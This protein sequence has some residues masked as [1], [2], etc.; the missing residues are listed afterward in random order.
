M[1]APYIKHLT[2][3]EIDRK[4][5]L[6]KYMARSIK[7]AAE[8]VKLAKGANPKVIVFVDDK[9]CD[10]IQLATQ[11]LKLKDVTGVPEEEPIEIDDYIKLSFLF[12]GTDSTIMTNEA[13]K[14]TIGKSL[15]TLNS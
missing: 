7:D 4:A 11:L 2:S 5:I 13:L 8:N 10:V 9:Y 6:T 14:Q 3:K 15:K 1:Y 12:D